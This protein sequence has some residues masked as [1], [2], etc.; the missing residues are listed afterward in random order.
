MTTSMNQSFELLAKKDSWYN[1]TCRQQESHF[2]ESLPTTSIK[3]QTGAVETIILGW[4]EIISVELCS[5]AKIVDHLGDKFSTSDNFI[6][7][8]KNFVNF[9]PFP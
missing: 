7:K 2:A 8:M 3:K 6:Q 9:I 5:D 1:I 4:D